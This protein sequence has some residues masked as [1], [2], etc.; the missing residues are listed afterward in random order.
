MSKF[1]STVSRRDFMKAIGLAGAGISAAAATS[2]VFHDLD[3]LAS[4]VPEGV[5]EKRPWWQKERSYLDMTTEVDWDMKNRWHG[6]YNN[7]NAH[8]TTEH[9]LGRMNQSWEKRKNDCLDNRQG[10]DLRSRVLGRLGWIP[11]LAIQRAVTSLGEGLEVYDEPS[12]LPTPISS[13]PL[14]HDQLGVPRWEGTAEENARMIRSMIRWAGGSTVAFG[15]IDEKTIK[16][17]D[18]VSGGKEVVFEDVE[19]PYYT[20]TKM[21]IPNT[22]KYVITT[23]VRQPL[24]D[25]RFSPSCIAQ[26]AASRAYGQG[27]VIKLYIQ[28]FL[29]CLGYNG[30][31]APVTP[32]VAWGVATG[33]GELS[34]AKSLLTPEVGMVHR[35]TRVFLTDLPLPVTNPIDAGMN[36]FCY[37]CKRC[38]EACP[39]GAIPD[40]K[41][42]SWDI[43]SINATAE[44]PD[45]LQPELF[46]N[47]GHKSW[48]NNHFACASYWA[49]VNTYC[50]L[51]QGV[52]V[53]SKL[54]DS[55][56]HETVKAVVAT[57]PIFNGFFYNM[58][59][60][61]NYNTFGEEVYKE[62]WDNPD[63]YQPLLNWDINW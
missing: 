62:W 1:H 44:N 37:D 5:A 11:M 34:R 51:C 63:K 24:S 35:Y 10:W 42:P 9:V 7:W 45:H 15:R 48:F 54:A 31:Y 22:C 43:T 30:I 46:N 32:N 4:S 59:K 17:I 21:V 50:G 14:R 18:A 58:D 27:E 38:I 28:A 20:T 41:E 26:A 60:T 39:P 25:T 8:L 53:F 16:L 33:L 40:Y 29:R 13:F 23:I 2:P 52:C 12:N 6:Q 47:Q 19:K 56:V 55:S 36:R 49:Q 61:F 57:T 3:E